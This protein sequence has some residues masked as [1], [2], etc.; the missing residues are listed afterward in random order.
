GGT[1]DIALRLLK[2]SGNQAEVTVC[3]LTESMLQ[4]G[5]DRMIDKNILSGINWVCGN[6]EDL[7]IADESVDIYTIA[8]GLRNVTH[9]DKA[10]REAAR[11]L[12]PGG[13]FFCLEFSKPRMAWLGQ[14]YDK[15]S[16]NLIPKIG[17][18]V[19]Q[20]KDSYQYLVESIRKFPD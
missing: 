5:R 4:V 8:F 13:Q 3:D 11:V 14:V 20:D 2:A 17:E 16:F 15:Y 6:A 18:F 7:P 12:K 9:I 1:G 10:L 19:A